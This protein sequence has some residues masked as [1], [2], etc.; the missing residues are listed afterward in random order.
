MINNGNQPPVFKSESNPQ[1]KT[2]NIN[3]ILVIV[4]LISCMISVYLGVQYYQLNQRYK[5]STSNDMYD[6][7][8]MVTDSTANDLETNSDYPLLFT[9]NS[10]SL[11]YPQDWSFQEL[12]DSETFPLK[13]RLSTIYSDGH[14]IALEKNGVT[15]IIAIEPENQGGTQGIFLNDTHFNDFLAQHDEIIIDNNI[16]YLNKSHSSYDS[17]LTAASGPYAWSSLSEYIPE[18]ITDSG[19]VYR[20]YEGIIKRNGYSHNVI[21]AGQT[22]GLTDPNLQSEMIGILESITW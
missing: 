14:A 21:V 11:Y 17:L 18:L 16:F 1:P 12:S 4:T 20:G 9:L 8:N 5:L 15:L 10:F 19:R 22:E 3:P 6:Q 7:T 13:D 2:F